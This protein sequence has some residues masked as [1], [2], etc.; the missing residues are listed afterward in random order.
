MEKRLAAAELRYNAARER[1]LKSE[2]V[3]G[4][5]EFP[6]ARR[7]LIGIHSCVFLWNSLQRFLDVKVPCRW[8]YPA[9]SQNRT[10]CCGCYADDKPHAEF[11][12]QR[13]DGCYTILPSPPVEPPLGKAAILRILQAGSPIEKD[14]SPSII[15]GFDLRSFGTCM[16]FKSL[17][18]DCHLRICSTVS[19]KNQEIQSIVHILRHF[20]GIK[21]VAC[22]VAM[23]Y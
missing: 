2:P 1:F 12:L 23:Y 21:D 20:L 19:T 13:Q 10:L 17:C 7:Y 9:S 8:N 15:D 3:T 22:L 4:N 5:E 14:P 16:S 11:R 6:E 18:N